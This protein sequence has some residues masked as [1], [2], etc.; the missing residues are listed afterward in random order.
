MGTSHIGLREAILP[1]TGAIAP[2]QA[3][4]DCISN[5][6]EFRIRPAKTPG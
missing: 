1:I 3:L 6:A 4:I 2:R 5:H